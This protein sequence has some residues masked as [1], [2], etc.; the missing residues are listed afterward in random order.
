MWLI[1]GG[2]SHAA[3]LVD[4]V[5]PFPFPQVISR[6]LASF[7]SRISEFAQVDALLIRGSSP[8]SSTRDNC[9]SSTHVNIAVNKPPKM[10]AYCVGSPRSRRDGNEYF[11]YRLHG[12]Q[13][14]ASF[15]DFKPAKKFSMT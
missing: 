2:A 6:A 9:S 13:I 15:S 8:L 1:R 10:R 14:N 3:E 7:P 5:K 4:A 11:I 12:K